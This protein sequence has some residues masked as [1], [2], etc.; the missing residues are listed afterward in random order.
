MR[1]RVHQDYG[2]WLRLEPSSSGE[3]VHLY[4][5]GLA[6]WTRLS[7]Q[8]P[9]GP[10]CARGPPAGAAQLQF[11]KPHFGRRLKCPTCFTPRL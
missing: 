11:G 1:K 4:L 3:I 8:A 5:T 6:R 7:P 2:V 10:F 9:Q